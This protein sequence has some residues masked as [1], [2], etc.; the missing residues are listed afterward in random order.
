MQWIIV[1]T[2]IWRISHGVA[3]LDVRAFAGNQ[4]VAYLEAERGDDV[5]LLT[6]RVVKQSDVRAAVGVIFDRGDLCRHAVLIVA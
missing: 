3:D 6:I 4:R 5:A 2:G 1:P